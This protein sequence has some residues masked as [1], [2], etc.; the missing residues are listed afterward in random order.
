MKQLMLTTFI[1]FNLQI[2]LSA[3]WKIQAN[4]QS[5]GLWSFLAVQDEKI[6]G[7]GVLSPKHSTC[8]ICQRGCIV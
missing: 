5:R 4:Y 1:A 8:P 3:Q 7:L 6:L 2:T